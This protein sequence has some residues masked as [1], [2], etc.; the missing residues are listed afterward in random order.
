[1]TKINHNGDVKLDPRDLKL[2]NKAGSFGMTKEEKDRGRERLVA[3]LDAHP[4]QK[5]TP[6]PY[7][8]TRSWIQMLDL[9]EYVFSHKIAAALLVITLMVCISKGMVIAAKKAVPGSAFYPFKIYTY[10]KV[11]S[12]LALN[13][14]ANAEVDVEQATVRLQEAEQLAANGK[15][16]STTENQVT[17][18]FKK[19]AARATSKAKELR[20]IGDAD[21]AALITSNLESSLASHQNILKKL[22]AFSGVA[23]TTLQPIMDL[24]NSSLSSTTVDRADSEYLV[25]TSSNTVKAAARQAHN[26]SRSIID[27]AN[28]VINGAANDDVK[29]SA[30][31]Q[32]KIAEDLVTQGN[33]NFKKGKYSDAYLL[34]GKAHRQAD[35]ASLE[36]KLSGSVNSKNKRK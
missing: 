15:L 13:P 20:D 7:A 25:A 24:V 30:A 18:A 12:F 10:E 35:Q 1:M 28:R 6:S 22:A 3:F 17:T 29:Q 27:N 11:Q 4:L 21:T 23:S 9:R 19:S 32:L 8:P 31:D 26:D 5:Q 2:F 36:V 16:D 33:D 34:Y 14:Q